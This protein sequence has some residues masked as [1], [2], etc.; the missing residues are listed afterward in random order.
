[1]FNVDQAVKQ[2]IEIEVGKN[3]LP[4]FDHLKYLVVELTDTLAQAL[5]EDPYYQHLLIL[6]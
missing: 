4:P 1:M 2:Q 5:E 6:N 3:L